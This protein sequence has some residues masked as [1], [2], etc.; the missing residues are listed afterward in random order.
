[1]INKPNKTRP[2]I[3]VS[4]EHHAMSPFADMQTEKENSLVFLL[5]DSHFRKLLSGCPDTSFY[6]NYLRLSAGLPRLWGRG[7]PLA[8]VPTASPA[9]TYFLQSVRTV[10]A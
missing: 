6:N 1:L 5:E 3:P 9:S 2:A 4:L 7:M 8:L 10:P